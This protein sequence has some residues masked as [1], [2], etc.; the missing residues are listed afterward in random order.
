M[1]DE[2][3]GFLFTA[4]MNALV[5]SDAGDPLPF[6]VSFGGF[7]DGAFSSMVGVI[8]QSDGDRFTYTAAVD[9]NCTLQAQTNAPGEPSKRF[10]Y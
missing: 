4:F 6:T 8:V 2:N 1:G 3:N 7:I 9:N 10:G 5:R